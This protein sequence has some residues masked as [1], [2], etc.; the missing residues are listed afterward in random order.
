MPVY[1]QLAICKH[2][3]TLLD[4]IYC[5]FSSHFFL[6]FCLSFLTFF[7]CPLSNR[8]FLLPVGFLT[9]YGNYSYRFFLSTSKI[10]W[11]QWSHGPPYYAALLLRSVA[12][13]LSTS[14]PG[15]F[16]YTKT[17]LVSHSE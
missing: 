14:F 8:L 16:L 13:I 10:F 3:S 5:S 6:F 11:D 17:C 2:L 9:F 15:S 4:T 7:V 12:S 1:R